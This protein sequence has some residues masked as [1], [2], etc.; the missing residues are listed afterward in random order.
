MKS[1]LMT[2]SS[3]LLR[4]ATRTS[5]RSRETL[6]YLHHI[7]RF[8]SQ[9]QRRSP[10]P[11]DWGKLVPDELDHSVKLLEVSQPG[12][13]RQEVGRYP[14][15]FLRDSC[16][17]LRC[18]DPNSTQKNFDTCQIPNDITIDSVQYQDDGVHIKWQNDIPGFAD[19]VTFVPRKLLLEQRSNLAIR[20]SHHN[21][22]GPKLWK[23]RDAESLPWM[24]YDKYMNDDKILL[25][26]V[27]QL[28]DYGFLLLKN[29]EEN[30]QSVRKIAGRIGI[31][32]NTFYGQ[33]WDVKSKKA[34]KNVAYTKQYLGL[35]MDL[36]YMNEP[37]GFQLL[38][39][40]KNDASGGNA[41]FS[42]AYNAF[43]SLSPEHISALNRLSLNYKYDNDGHQYSRTT[44]FIARREEG[45]PFG[46]D[47]IAYI[48][49]SP[50]F[51]GPL[52]SQNYGVNSSKMPV[53]MDA[54]R[55]FT[56]ATESVEN[57]LEYRYEAGDC[58]IF[59]NRRVLH[60]RREFDPET[61]ERWLKGCYVDSDVFNSKMRV[62]HDQLEP[63]DPSQPAVVYHESRDRVRKKSPQTPRLK[64]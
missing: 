60:G 12:S 45:R 58:V 17:C 1:S 16:K 40:L 49:H 42:D 10:G 30:E 3:S 31:I 36:L 21:N 34:A 37:P 7:S 15:L 9:T 20:T 8:S 2:C 4:C 29:V 57:L 22:K 6:W 63:W 13:T 61:G 5:I 50:P 52:P 26:A 46:R 11:N 14:A 59:N 55:S 64:V 62:L 43:L 51:Q 44:N 19:H 56:E 41:L 47:N 39:C 54:L 25:Q 53:M 28:R 33:T 48:N 27:K 18:V 24:Q 23:A 38:H 35:H 32:R